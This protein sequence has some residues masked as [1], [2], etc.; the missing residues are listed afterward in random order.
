MNR[1][2][3]LR[4]LSQLQAAIPRMEQGDYSWKLN[5]LLV[6]ETTPN[7]DH[8]RL[9]Y[10]AFHPGDGSPWDN[11][12]VPGWQRCAGCPVLDEH[13]WRRQELD[14]SP[15]PELSFR[16]EDGSGADAHLGLSA[17]WNRV[18]AACFFRCLGRKIEEMMS[19]AADTR[20]P[21]QNPGEAPVPPRPSPAT[22]RMMHS[23]RRLPEAFLEWRNEVEAA[24]TP[25][26]CEF[27][28]T[29]CR[30]GT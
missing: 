18:E 9:F 10:S 17:Q 6:L 3:K 20:E 21:C 15:Q 13:G 14:R 27:I 11:Y 19:A 7:M 4:L 12:R 28:H 25:D 26:P 23:S 30:T 5:G 22:R 24:L 16:E 8:R 29:W 1:E 2:Q